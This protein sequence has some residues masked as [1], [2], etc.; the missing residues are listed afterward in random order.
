MEL[1]V[2]QLMAAFIAILLLLVAAA[3]LVRSTS[4]VVPAAIG[5]LIVIPFAGFAAYAIV[6]GPPPNFTLL[7]FAGL[8]VSIAL[9]AGV[10]MVGLMVTR[11]GPLGLQSLASIGIATVVL[12]QG[13]VV[14]LSAFLAQWQPAYAIA[15][16]GVDAAWIAMW[17]PGR[18]RTVSSTAAIEIAAPRPR[19]FAFLADPANWPRYDA[20]LVSVRVEP[21]GALAAGSE[22]TQVRRYERAVRG[23]AM[24]PDTVEVTSVVTQVTDGESIASAARDGRSNATLRFADHDSGTTVTTHA[25]LTVPLRLALVGGAVAMRAQRRQ[26]RAK[27]R[28]NLARLKAV[29]EQP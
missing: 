24:L 18:T 3:G 22:V 2:G 16:L 20:D 28:E 7:P 21:V 23:P 9:T 1:P 4:P 6:P 25:R 12:W 19:V 11:R 14:A 10:W 13:I 8:A 26:R 5:L 17:L 27:A 15:N 29:L